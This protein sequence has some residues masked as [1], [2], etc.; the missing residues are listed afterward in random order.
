MADRFDTKAFPA[1]NSGPWM[2][3]PRFKYI[4]EVQEAEPLNAPEAN[5]HAEVAQ[6]I[7]IQDEAH[8]PIVEEQKQ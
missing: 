2:G 3:Q 8:V 6:P 1:D 5:P 4:F 7:F